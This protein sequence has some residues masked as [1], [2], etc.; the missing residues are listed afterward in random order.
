M[1]VV[2]VVLVKTSGVIKGE[3]LFKVV[4]SSNYLSVGS[5]VGRIFQLNSVHE[6]S[7]ESKLIA[8]PVNKRIGNARIQS[9]LTSCPKVSEIIKGLTT[10]QNKLCFM[11]NYCSYLTMNNILIRVFHSK[12]SQ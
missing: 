10:L 11:P 2:E 1:E 8:I 7:L 6:S 9:K 3:Y 12:R 4:P 5:K